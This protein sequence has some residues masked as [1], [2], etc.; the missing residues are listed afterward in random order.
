MNLPN[1]GRRD[2]AAVYARQHPKSDELLMWCLV[3]EEREQ[4]RQKLIYGCMDRLVG[5]LEW[6]KHDLPSIRAAESI[7]KT[8]IADGNYLYHNDTLMHN[9]IWQA[10]CLTRDK[11]YDEAISALRES[12]R[13]AAAYMEVLEQAKKEAVPYTCPVLNRLHFDGKDMSVS[14]TTTLAEGFKEYLTWKHFDAL[15]ERDDF[16]ALLNL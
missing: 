14:G 1:I 4:I 15:R 12:Y 6:G 10:M 5:W 9:Q 7:I 8:I 11:R 16:K 3:G 2:E 13:Y